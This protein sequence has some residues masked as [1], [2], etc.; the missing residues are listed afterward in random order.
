MHLHSDPLS[1]RTDVELLSAL[2]R[3]WL[4]P[5]TDTPETPEQKPVQEN[6]QKEASLTTRFDLNAPVT[7]E[8]ANFS[9]GERQ[10]VA[11]CRALVKDSRI[12]VMVSFPCGYI[13][14]VSHVILI[15]MRQPQMS[16]LKPT[17][18]S[19]VQSRQN[20]HLLLCSV[21]HIDLIR[22]VCYRFLMRTFY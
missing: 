3:A 9:A 12:I 14:L 18:K 16:T 13:L 17:R 10:L 4:L 21:L 5:Q 2:R 19:N 22:L 1:L 15:R 11:L 8:G 7:E 6:G 20:L